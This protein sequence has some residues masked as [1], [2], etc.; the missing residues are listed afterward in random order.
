MKFFPG[1]IIKV[2][3]YNLINIYT[4][5]K[6]FMPK[7]RLSHCFSLTRQRRMPHMEGQL[8]QR[9][10]AIFHWGSTSLPLSHS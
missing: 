10:R 8:L 7:Y 9:Q 6:N 5:Y 4:N 2:D 1:R 3:A